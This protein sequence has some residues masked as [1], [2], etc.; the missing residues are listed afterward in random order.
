LVSVS[1]FR[2]SPRLCWVTRVDPEG[3]LGLAWPN[4]TLVF[5]YVKPG[6]DPGSGLTRPVY[7]NH[8]F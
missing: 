6:H 7:P 5:I 2:V 3:H 8:N 1:I 4:A